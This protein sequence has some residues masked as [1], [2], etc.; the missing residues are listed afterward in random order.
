MRSDYDR[1]RKFATAM[2]NDMGLDCFE[3][4]GA[5]Y[6]FPDVSSVSDSGESFAEELLK[7]KLVA[8]VPGSAFGKSGHKHV[9]CTYASS[10]KT[11]NLAFDRMR[12]FI[13]RRG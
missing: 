6:C 13:K 9:R 11:L 2:L 10:V 4:T 8:V 3:P 7:Q 12:E 1:R 5:F